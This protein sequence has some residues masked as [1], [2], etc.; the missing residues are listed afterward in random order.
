MT[1]NYFSCIM[2]RNYFLACKLDLVVGLV[3]GGVGW[4]VGCVGGWMD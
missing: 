1:R 3:G 2:N 4:A